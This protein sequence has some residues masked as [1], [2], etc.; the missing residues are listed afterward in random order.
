MLLG[1]PGTASAIPA[2]TLTDPTGDNCRD[3]ATPPGNWCGPDISQAVFSTPG[4]GNLH[5]D[6]TYASIPTNVIGGTPLEELPA[7]VE[8]GIYPKS[9]TSPDYANL[10]FR[11]VRAP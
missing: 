2:Q 6:I 5:V 3:F 7:Y 1:A 9:A 10:A 11:F 4:D 8:L